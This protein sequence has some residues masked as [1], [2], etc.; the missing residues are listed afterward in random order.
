[1]KTPLEILKEVRETFSDPT[2]WTKGTLGRKANGNPSNY[3][4]EACQV[5]LLGAIYCS[6]FGTATPIE[7]GGL[8]EEVMAVAEALGF[9][10]LYDLTGFNDTTST[11]EPVLDLINDTIKDLE[12][13]E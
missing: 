7:A 4:E 12:T 13:T 5:C 1:M 11:I 2:K 10:M 9:T 8:N 6:V 3:G